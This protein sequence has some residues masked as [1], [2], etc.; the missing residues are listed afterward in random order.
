[1]LAE[2]QIYRIDHYLGKETVQN[3]L[4]FRFANSIFEPLWNRNYIDHVQIT[5]AETVGVEH[6]GP[7]YD[8]VGVV[9]DM[10]QNHLLQ[11]LALVAMEPPEAATAEA[12]RDEKVRALRAVRPLVVDGRTSAVRAQYR[13]G[14]ISDVAVVGYREEPGASPASMS[15]TYA[16]MRVFVDTE[17]WRDV[18]FYL[19][20]GKRMAKRTTEI[21]LVF[22]EPK[23]LM[24]KPCPGERPEPNALVFRIQ[25]NDGM[26]L[27]ISVKIP[28]AALA[29]TPGIEITPVEM[30]F[31][32]ADAFGD[33]AHSA[34]AT[35]LLDA[36]RGDATLF[37]RS[38]EV[39]AGWTLTDPLLRLWESSGETNIA[40][41]AAG[42]WGPH[43]ADDL[44]AADGF[45][46]RRP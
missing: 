9:R 7:F 20:S 11:M 6:R 24:Y 36:M 15:P 21:A 46:W 17:R 40:T 4:V 12:I 30:A 3:V 41:Y 42:S 35:L 45:A 26:S 31:A 37:T 10:F 25:P 22:R 33:G 1:M 2:E 27:N 23:R 29:L 5:V 18:P 8:R 16:A 39:E 34:Y 44:L 19:R 43:E 32:F 13:D 38:D 28:G 14:H